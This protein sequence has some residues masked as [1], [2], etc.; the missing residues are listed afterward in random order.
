MIAGKLMITRYLNN[1]AWVI[2]APMAAIAAKRINA[3]TTGIPSFANV[4]SIFEMINLF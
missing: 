1:A 2:K 4:P 3:K